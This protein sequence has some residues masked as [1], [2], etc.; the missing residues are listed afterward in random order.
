MKMTFRI[1]PVGVEEE[2][3]ATGRLLPSTRFMA[4]TVTQASA[5][6]KNELV[7]P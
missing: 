3:D 1:H 5:S 4:G 7:N 6:G 2:K